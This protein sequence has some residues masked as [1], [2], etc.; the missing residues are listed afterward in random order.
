MSDKK[1]KVIKADKQR[2]F[3]VTKGFNVE[4]GRW[5][6]GQKVNESDLTPADIKALLEMDAIE[7]S[8]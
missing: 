3:I 7:E 8:K 1:V 2:K 4:A 6:A 5:E